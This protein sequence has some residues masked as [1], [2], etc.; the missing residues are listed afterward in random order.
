LERY[1]DVTRGEILFARGVLLVEGDA[2]R[3]LLPVLASKRGIDLDGLGISVCAVGSAEF[4]PLVKLLGP[5]GLDIPFA[6]LT[7]RDPTSSGT[8]LGEQ[9][10]ATQILPVLADQFG[11]PAPSL[12]DAAAHGV[13]LNSHTLE[14]DLMRSGFANAMSK[15][16]QE[17]TTNHVAH[18][19]MATAVQNL[20]NADVVAILKDIRAIGK[21]RFAQR[22]ASVIDESAA[23]AAPDAIANAFAYLLTRVS[24]E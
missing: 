15:V 18:E 12:D 6:I 13:F 7:D 23:V 1:L 24:A 16:M 8:A 4:R 2:E 9:R 3:Y 14:V 17:L 11:I 20:D 22:L 19:R 10:V 21:G 5:K